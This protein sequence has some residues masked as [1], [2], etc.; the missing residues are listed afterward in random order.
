M[1]QVMN[2]NALDARFLRPSCHLAVQIGFGHRE[3]PFVWFVIIK[4]LGVFLDQSTEKGWHCDQ[5]ATL[6]CL[7]FHDQ[8]FALMASVVFCDRQ[9]FGKKILDVR[10][11]AALKAGGQGDRYTVQI[12]GH[13]SYLF[14]ERSPNISGINLGR[15]FVERK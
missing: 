8:I 5:A 10:P 14:F 7:G 11:A 15:W 3:K 6:G 13:Q 9:C 2:A 1:S 4:L 12:N